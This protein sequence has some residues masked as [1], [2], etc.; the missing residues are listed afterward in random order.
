LWVNRPVHLDNGLGEER[1]R[2]AERLVSLGRYDEA[3]QWAGLAEKAYPRPGLVHFR[4]AQRLLMREQPE[5]AITHLQKAL[6]FDP[7]QPEVEYLLGATLLDDGHPQD[8]IP[9]LRHALANGGRADLAGYDLVRALGSVGRRDEAI[10]LLQGLRPADEG[11]AD[12]WMA[13]GEAA[14]SLRDG[15][16]AATFFRHAIEARPEL[17]RAHVGLA[18]ASAALG[19]LQD[20]RTEAQEALKLDA[21][22]TRAAQLL[23][24]L[25][26]R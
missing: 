10:Q 12:R 17:A 16:L 26:Q 15:A 11:D 22:D 3:E 2:M 1:T 6:Q 8:A 5:A 21:S 13:F 19:R 23:Q 9:I 25:N 4:V 7:G 20:A 18:A 24:M 14:M